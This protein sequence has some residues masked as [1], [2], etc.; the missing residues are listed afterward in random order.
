[1]IVK[2]RDVFK[3]EPSPYLTGKLATYQLRWLNAPADAKNAGLDFITQS[4]DLSLLTGGLPVPQPL[5]SPGVWEFRAQIATPK[6][7]DW[8]PWVRFTYFRENPI[9]TTPQQGAANTRPS[10]TAILQ[11][12]MSQTSAPQCKSGF[13]WRTAQ[14]TD[15]VCAP[16]AS[17]DRV[18]QENA[19]A[20]S[21]RSPTG[22]PYGPNTCLPGFVWREAFNG[23]VVCVPPA[24]RTMAREENALSASRTMTSSAGSAA[25]GAIGVL[26]RGVDEPTGPE[27]NQTVDEQVGKENAP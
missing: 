23:D 12:T 19:T 17:R 22:G 9:L 3:I 14:P 10:S 2:G 25:S 4:V 27:G 7:G 24:S 5:L 11:G 13:V 26:R 6:V 15:L 8:S 20:A 1:M 21:R 18:K 16:P